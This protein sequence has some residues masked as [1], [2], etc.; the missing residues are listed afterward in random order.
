MPNTLLK[1]LIKTYNG[2]KFK[3]I[4]ADPPWRFAN[5]NSKASPE[6]W[7]F[8]RYNTMPL[9]D[10][11]SLPVRDIVSNQA[12]IYLWVPISLIQDGISVMEA[13]GFEYKTLL[14]WEKV[15]KDGEISN[16]GMGF[17]FRNATELVLFGVKGKSF[18]TLQPARTQ[19]NVI[20]SQRLEHSRKPDE[21]FNIIEA[22]SHPPY[23][24]LFSRCKRK[25]W[26]CWG[27]QID[28]FKQNGK[29]QKQEERASLPPQ[30]A[31]TK[32]TTAQG[33]RA[34]ELESK[35]TNQGEGQGLPLQEGDKMAYKV[36]KWRK[37]RPYLYEQ[38]TYREKGAVKTKNTYLG[39]I[40]S[41]YK[42]GLI[43]DNFIKENN[44]ADKVKVAT[45]PLFEHTPNGHNDKVYNAILDILKQFE[46]GDI[47]RVIALTVNPEFDVPCNKWSLLNNLILQRNNTSDA[48]GFRQWQEV[49]RHV[50]KG[51][52]AISIL[53]PTFKKIKVINEDGKDEE[54]EFITGFRGV[55]VFRVEDTEG[56]P[57]DYENLEVPKLPL[58]EVAE[59]WGV[60]VKAIGKNRF[61][62]GCYNSLTDKI[63]L[64]SPEECVFF[65]ELAH[66]SHG[67]LCNLREQP[68]W[69]KEVIAELSASVLCRLAGKSPE[70]MGQHYKYIS[71][72]AEKEGKDPIKACYEVISEVDKVIN[73]IL[74]TAKEC[75]DAKS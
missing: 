20:K 27:D 70:N 58:L 26:I 35:Q 25:G 52:K 49:G 68:K 42:K 18:K 75:E 72:Y 19:V 28:K 24:E 12:H 57:L 56:E 69:Q 46:S 21:I 29:Q 5:R 60:E 16:G 17:Y 47:P 54:K 36:I 66:C 65:H 62:L 67:R 43:D 51:C 74:D 32:D 73:L 13:W 1:T 53:A 30:V 15:R 40:E 9:K 55:P 71:G 44:L 39:S 3:T 50:K 37:N 31:T 7:K 63:E 45:T 2:C 10:I 59:Q 34:G 14:V 38:K 64:A 8:F 61:Y 23:L 41:A 22:C 6:Y 4:L 11:I 33:D 48:R